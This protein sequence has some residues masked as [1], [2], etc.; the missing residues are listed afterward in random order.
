MIGPIIDQLAAST[1]PEVLVGKVNVDDAPDV[2][3]IL[4]FKAFLPSFC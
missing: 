4:V 3:A 2:A 1:G